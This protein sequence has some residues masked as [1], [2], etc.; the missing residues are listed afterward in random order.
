MAN[1]Y[2]AMPDALPERP[3]GYKK[4][5]G[6]HINMGGGVGTASYSVFNAEGVRMPF[7]YAYRVDKKKPENNYSG[8]I[9][10]GHED[11][12]L[13]WAEL[14]AIWPEWIKTKK[15]THG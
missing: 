10:P 3:T 9:L 4:Q 15:E 1:E 7:S 6:M 8:L 12:A 11:K 14:R 2:A 13:T 5:M